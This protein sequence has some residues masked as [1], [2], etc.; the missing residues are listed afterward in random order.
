MS[1]YILWGIAAVIVA[2]VVPAFGPVVVLIALV[3][4][5]AYL[6]RGG[7]KPGRGAINPRK[8]GRRGDNF[9]IVIGLFGFVMLLGSE[10]VAHVIDRTGVSG[11]TVAGLMIVTGILF[12]LSPRGVGRA[13]AALGVAATLGDLFGRNPDQGV[14]L[15]IVFVMLLWI[16]GA[17]RMRA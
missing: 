7:L 14:L 4:I 13:L 6:F 5:F 16:V 17:F 2:S 10:S 8:G 3:A 11:E 9:D 12:A 1:R 15:L